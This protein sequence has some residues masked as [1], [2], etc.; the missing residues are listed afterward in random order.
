MKKLVWG[1]LCLF[2]Q[3]SG[4]ASFN[5][6]WLVQSLQTKMSVFRE[7]HWAVLKKNHTRVCDS[8]DKRGAFTSSLFSFTPLHVA[9]LTLDSDELG[10]IWM[11]LFT[12]NDCRVIK[13]RQDLEGRTALHLAVHA[14][15]RCGVCFLL[16][17]ELATDTV[18]KEGR[19]AQQLARIYS[20]LFSDDQERKEIC[21]L[22]EEGIMALKNFYPGE[23]QDRVATE[24]LGE[25]KVGAVAARLEDWVTADDSTK[26]PF[27][28]SLPLRADRSRQDIS[29]E[30]KGTEGDVRMLLKKKRERVCFKGKEVFSTIV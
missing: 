17:H 22:L 6:E 19:T 21:R 23:A 5:K 8:I 10:G 14:G 30:E 25:K 11:K 1:V 16:Y 12:H 20:E 13:D 2:F 24:F 9:A 18:D 28:L 3:S 7:L 26:R 29:E 4:S 27:E 15:N